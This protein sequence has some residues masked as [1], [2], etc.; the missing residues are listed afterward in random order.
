MTPKLIG[1]GLVLA[2]VTVESFAQLCL[3]LSSRGG[4]PAVD[5]SEDDSAGRLA[6]PTVLYRGPPLNLYLAGGI[7]LYFLEV[8]LYTLALSR[9]DLSIAFPL[10]S[11][12]FV[13]VALLSKFILGEAVG[14]IRGLGVAC[15]LA[16][17][18]LIAF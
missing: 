6:L 7:L 13:G 8:L 11:L 2:A 15:I 9:L 17:T 1:L 4:K 18:I 5:T 12:S 10:G 16:G 3:K 14:W